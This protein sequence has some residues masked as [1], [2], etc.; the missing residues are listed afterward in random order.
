MTA[1]KRSIPK[2]SARATSTA[3]WSR[4]V[5]HDQREASKPGLSGAV[6]EGPGRP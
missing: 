4:M 6:D 5:I 1:V 3:T 2:A